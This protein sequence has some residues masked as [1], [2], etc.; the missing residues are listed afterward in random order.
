MSEAPKMNVTSIVTVAS[1]ALN[2]FLVAFLLGHNPPPPPPPP[3]PPAEAMM[4]EPPPP[5]PGGPEGPHGPGP[6]GPDGPGGPGG[7]HHRPPFMPPSA[8]FTPEEMK[9]DEPF[10]H[11]HF[12]KAHKLRQDFATQLS[13]GE[14]TP[15]VINAHFKELDAVTGELK[16]HFHQKLIE[17]IQRMTPLERK[18]FAK[19][20]ADF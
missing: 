15:D 18:D 5:P 17:K 4:G 19:Q 12:E 2:I 13:Q 14:V 10:M 1:M 7:K 6:G 9:A 11:E 3:P 16:E 20:M 8:L